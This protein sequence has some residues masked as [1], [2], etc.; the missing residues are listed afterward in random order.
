MTVNKV[1]DEKGEIMNKT[2][3]KLIEDIY[4]SD[5]LTLEPFGF[6]L[7]K[8]NVEELAALLYPILIRDKTRKSSSLIHLN[9]PHLWRVYNLYKLYKE[10]SLLRLVLVGREYQEA[11]TAFVNSDLVYEDEDNESILNDGEIYITIINDKQ[12][13]DGIL[14][15]YN[16]FY[17]SF[18]FDSVYHHSGLLNGSDNLIK[19]QKYDL[20]THKLANDPNCPF[21]FHLVLSSL[22]IKNEELNFILAL[23]LHEESKHEMMIDYANSSLVHPFISDYTNKR[24]KVN[25]DDDSVSNEK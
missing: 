8:E 16:V 6:K 17:L 4:K 23:S 22:D 19:T 13:L 25:R 18:D 14:E 21:L 10:K 9:I 2:Y 12:N 24:E 20:H 1:A 7:N 11:Y 5:E 15:K 3:I